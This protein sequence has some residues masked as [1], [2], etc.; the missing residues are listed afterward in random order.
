LQSAEDWGYKEKIQKHGSQCDYSSGFGGKY[1]VQAD[2]QDKSAVGWDH[3]EKVE[4]H[5]S[6]RGN[7]D[8]TANLLFFFQ[9]FE[10]GIIN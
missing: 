2:R 4:K 8:R 3:V 9:V 10:R 1:G 7:F 6:Q 5:E